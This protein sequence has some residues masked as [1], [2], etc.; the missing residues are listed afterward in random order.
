M[1]V[2]QHIANIRATLPKGVQLVCV[3]KF[4]T[5][6]AIFE[7]YN[8]GERDFG[9]SRAQ[10]LIKKAMSLP[11]DINWHFIGHLQKNKVK[12]VVPI[13]SLI[14]S[15]DSEEL[16]NEIERCATR[17]CENVRVLLQVHIAQEVQKFGFSPIELKNLLQEN[18]LANLAH[19]KIAGLMGMA[20][21]TSDKTILN[22]EFKMLKTLFDEVKSTYFPHDKNFAV[23]SM[24]MSEDYLLAIDQGSNMIRIGSS[25]FGERNKC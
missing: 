3:S 12:L 19:I 8:A 14:Q 23:L 1:S 13:A 20:T 22:N 7:A 15:V 17:R 5:A 6:D 18:H 11:K 2:K 16:L 9:E 24:G 21:F 10:E 4:Q 25:I